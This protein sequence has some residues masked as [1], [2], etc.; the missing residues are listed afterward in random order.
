MINTLKKIPK[1][2]TDMI[3]QCKWCQR[4]YTPRSSGGSPQKFCSRECKHLFEKSIRQWAYNEHTKGSL[5]LSELQHMHSSKKEK[6][7]RLV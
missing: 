4:D 2:R 3:N 7:K 5:N 1:G 6:L